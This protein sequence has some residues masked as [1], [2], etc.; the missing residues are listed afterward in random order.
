MTLPTTADGPVAPLGE[1]ALRPLPL[2]ATVLTSGFLADLQS[3]NAAVSIR[4]GADNLRHA[5]TWDNFGD[6]AAGAP[7]PA[8]PI[9]GYHG[10]CYQDGEAY[11]W[12]EAV[13]WE[14]GRTSD[15]PPPNDSEAPPDC[16]SWLRE[17][18]AEIAAAQDADG[19]LNTFVQ[20]GCRDVRYGGL[21]FDHEIFNNGA[22]IQS[23]IAQFRATG[24]TELLDVARRAADHL[25]REFGN[26]PGQRPG[27]CGHPVAEMA[28]V[29]LYR[30]TG[31]G[32]YLD[33]ARYFIDAR[34]QGLLAPDG[35]T[36][37]ATYLS[38]R[39]PVRQTTAPEGHAVRA[40]YLAAGATDVAIETGDDQLLTALQ[41]QW[42][43]M[44]GTKMYVT[45]G[46]GSR[47]DGEAFGNAYEL[48]SDVGYAETC[49]AI[50][51]LQ[52]NWRLLLATGRSRYADLFEWQLYNA[53]LP[54]V[55][56]DR[57]RFFYVNALQVRADSTDTD[58][59]APSGGRRPWFGTSCC[60]TN[61]MRTLACLQ[62]Y[63]AT[64]SRD[65]VQV[66]QYGSGRIRAELDAGSIV[67]AVDTDYPRDGQISITVE[68]APPGEV[69]IELRVPA[70]ADGATIALDGHPTGVA[71][72]QYAALRRQWST[73]H[74][75][76][77]FKNGSTV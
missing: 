77:I 21:D 43:Q 44:R 46:L 41:H 17:H 34:G 65:A 52:W 35:D 76:C 26:G 58:E 11:K 51:C 63:V 69:S 60:P 1:I 18:T 7:V 74:I 40:I 6:V 72:G 25:C 3:R 47:W 30:T 23:A 22:L 45:G 20:R 4:M 49:A 55:S 75:T 56:L 14:T 73:H 10:P 37:R 16:R 9:A 13:A 59:R 19:Y 2:T 29:E 57:T 61:L 24:G 64:S 62:A 8:D 33:L 38:D 50:A 32:R 48:P 31:V 68:Q 54:G 39:I 53:V 27:Y 36:H 42:E 15:A 67:L 66:Q 5:G 70:W 12:L 28:L 71:A